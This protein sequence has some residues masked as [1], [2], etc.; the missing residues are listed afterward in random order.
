MRKIGSNCKKIRKNREIGGD[1]K[2]NT[3]KNRKNWKLL[4]EKIGKN[5][6]KISKIENNPVTSDEIRKNSEN[7][8]NQ[9]KTEK[10]RKI[11]K[12]RKNQKHGQK[13]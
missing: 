7:R 10:I 4:L 5:H 8:K 9:K 11:R 6:E 3:R 1:K 13:N 12:I 2:K